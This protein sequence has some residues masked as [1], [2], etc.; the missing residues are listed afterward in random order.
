M[1]ISLLVAPDGTLEFIYNDSLRPLFDLGRPEIRRA[2]FVEPTANGQ[3]AADMSP[4]AAGVI[5]GPFV[6]RQ[7]ALD[8]E[9]AWLRD[10]LLGHL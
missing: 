6:T 7:E 8:A 1:N 3:W 2:S 4:V 9:T 10:H 5:L